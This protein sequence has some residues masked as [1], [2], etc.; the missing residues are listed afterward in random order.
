[1]IT[2]GFIRIAALTAPLKL[3]VS[4]PI[5]R[6]MTQLLLEEKRNSIGSSM[7][8]IFYWKLSLINLIIEASVVDLPLPV[9]PETRTNPFGDCD[10]LPSTGGS[11]SSSKEEIR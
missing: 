4:I 10:I 2:S 7:V 6:C 11:F 8:M 9:G 3:S 5:S 1:M